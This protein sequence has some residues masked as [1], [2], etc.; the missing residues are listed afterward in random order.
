MDTGAE[1]SSSNAPSSSLEYR[2]SSPNLPPNTKFCDVNFAE[3]DITD[4]NFVTPAELQRLTNF[5]KAQIVIDLLK[6]MDHFSLRLLLETLFA[7][8]APSSI[9]RYSGKFI[10]AGGPLSLMETWYDSNDPEMVNW[11][12]AKAARACEKEAQDLT[13]RAS[14]G[15]HAMDADFLRLKSSSITVEAVESFRVASLLERYERTTPNFQLILKHFIGKTGPQKSPG[16]RDP[17]MVCS[18]LE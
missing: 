7:Y 12:I 15:P 14:R 13:N 4:S 18:A 6:P 2:L 17:D 1:A 9:K 11:V 10:N 5:D 16:T 3:D 8:N